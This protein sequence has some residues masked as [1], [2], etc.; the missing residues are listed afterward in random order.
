MPRSR[1]VEG[2]D[3][4]GSKEEAGTGGRMRVWRAEVSIEW[5]NLVARSLFVWFFRLSA[6]KC[7]NR[8]LFCCI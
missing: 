2:D 3:Q 6:E 7:I 8:E 4:E 1:P 5:D